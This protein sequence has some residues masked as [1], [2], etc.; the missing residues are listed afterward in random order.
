M[1][2][3]H[4]TL[5]QADENHL[6]VLL[7]KGVLG[8]RT[9]KR[10]MSLQYLH[11]GKTYQ[12]VSDLLQVAYPTVLTWAKNYRKDGL[13]FLT[14]KARPGRPVKFDGEDRAKITA[15]ACSEAPEGYARWSLR[16]LADRLVSL[17]IVDE[18]SYSEVGLVLKKTNCSLTGSGNGALGS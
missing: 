8:V 11:S 9:Q 18:I 2:K 15:L 3:Q 17:E 6:T 5:T 13:S 7:S 4:I 14:D 10:A 1:K 16:L 12:E